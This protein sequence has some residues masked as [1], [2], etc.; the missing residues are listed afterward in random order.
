MVRSSTETRRTCVEQGTDKGGFRVT[1]KGGV[2]VVSKATSEVHG[3]RK[4]T[5]GRKKYAREER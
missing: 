1:D 4:R 3:A 5:K 2:D